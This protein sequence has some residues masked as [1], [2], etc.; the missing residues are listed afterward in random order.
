MAGI[1]SFS[2]IVAVLVAFAS[3]TAVAL[4]ISVEPLPEREVLIGTSGESPDTQQVLQGMS[5]VDYDIV[6]LS[7]AL[8]VQPVSG[9]TAAGA[10]QTVAVSEPGTWLLLATG[11]LGLALRRGTNS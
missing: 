1:R 6:V 2:A 9:C 7:T 4:P 5:F 10:C 8:P 3:A 11:L